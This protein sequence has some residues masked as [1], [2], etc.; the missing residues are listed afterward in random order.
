M[1]IKILRGDRGRWYH[2]TDNIGK[3]FCV[4]EYW[5]SSTIRFRVEGC[6]W[7]DKDDCVITELPESFC[8]KRCDDRDKWKKYIIWL[9]K[10][11]YRTFGG[12]T[13]T[14]YGV[15]DNRN[16]LTASN[17][18]SS[19]GTEIHIDDIIKHIHFY[20]E[21]MVV[22]SEEE[23]DMTTNEGRIAYAK[24]HYPAGTRYISPE[25]PEK[26]FTVGNAI[27]GQQYWLGVNTYKNCVLA[28]L[29]ENTLKGQFIYFFG[30][31][32]EI[33]K[34]EEKMETN[35]LEL[36][37]LF[38]E[39][40]TD[41]AKKLV[42]KALE[43]KNGCLNDLANFI[44]SADTPTPFYEIITGTKSEQK[45][46][47]VWRKIYI[48]KNTKTNMETQKLSRKGLKEIHS[49]ACTTWKTNLENYSKRNTLEDYIELTNIEVNHMFNSCTKEQLPIVSK[50]LKQDDGSV[51][52]TKFTLSGKGFC[53]DNFYIIR[54]REWGEYK[55]QSF[56]LSQRYD[57]EIKTDELGQ[58][59]L[60]PTKKK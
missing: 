58:L 60:I 29:G 15:I 57:W 2:N 14:F 20:S 33:V 13:H 59:C 11:Y 56:L 12:Y 27:E 9:N 28:S 6:G 51:D 30:K 17:D 1:K 55:K 22:E 21:P 37:R 8:V 39:L 24:K 5:D 46:N 25:Y 50:Y 3:E 45:A 40:P 23:F 26:V 34:E 42:Q 43:V 49:V 7:V 36:I 44:G 16:G 38:P 54:D 4:I 52:V 18:E 41:Y 32:A 10:T 47:Y 19:F 53:D 31:W 48:F 35:I